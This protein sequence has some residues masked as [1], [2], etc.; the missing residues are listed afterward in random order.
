MITAIVI[1]SGVALF[2]LFLNVFLF[3]AFK[4][5][6]RDLKEYAE[7]ITPIDIESWDEIRK[8]N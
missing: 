1:L 5:A 4:L 8:D 6:W 7:E 2:Q 3:H